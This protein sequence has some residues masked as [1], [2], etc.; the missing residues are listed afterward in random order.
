[1]NGIGIG[2][3]SD[4]AITRPLGVASLPGLAAGATA[5]VVAPIAG[6]IRFVDHRLVAFVDAEQR[7][8]ETDETN[9]LASADIACAVLQTAAAPPARRTRPR[10]LRP[11]IRRRSSGQFPGTTS[12]SRRS[13]IS[14]VMGA[15]RS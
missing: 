5:T 12:S 10:M 13:G 14:T 2:V 8:T 9:N 1:M 7:L 15:W 4:L 6:P 3:Y 11:S